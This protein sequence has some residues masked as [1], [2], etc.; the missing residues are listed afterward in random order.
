MDKLLK[1]L[2]IISEINHPS[3][4]ESIHFGALVEEVRR[5]FSKTIQAHGVEVTIDCPTDI[6][7]YSYPNLVEVVITNLFENALYFSVLQNANHA[8][9]ALKASVEDNQLVFSIRDNGIGVDASIRNRLFDMFFKG[10]TDSKGSGLGLYIVQKSVQALEGIIT[11]ESE[12]GR[13]TEF[14]VKLP[15][16]ANMNKAVLP[17]VA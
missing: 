1:K 13:Y 17:A 8:K 3:V 2:S 14:F 12:P 11:V 5:K 6:M 15:L 9:V 4:Y 7:F 16:Q 10:H